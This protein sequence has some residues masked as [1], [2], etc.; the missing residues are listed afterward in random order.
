MPITHQAFMNYRVG[1]VE[2]SEQALSV[3]RC[4][5]KGATVTQADSGLSAREWRELCDVFG[6]GAD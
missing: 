5:L 4:F 3:L 2:L 6:L 1:G